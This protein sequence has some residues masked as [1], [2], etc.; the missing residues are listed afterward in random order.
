L[1]SGRVGFID[2]DGNIEVMAA[3]ITTGNLVSDH[4]EKLLIKRGR[5]VS[6]ATLP[7]HKNYLD[8]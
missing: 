1:L 8:D 2:A 7:Q 6:L 4:L 5:S 3:G